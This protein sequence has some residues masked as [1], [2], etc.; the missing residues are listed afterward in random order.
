MF[1]NNLLMGAAAA[2]SGG[3]S[4]VSVG[5]S[6]LFTSNSQELE[7][8]PSG[9]GNVDKWT[10]STWVYFGDTTNSTSIPI[11]GAINTS[12]N[13]NAILISS[14]G[15]IYFQIYLS[16]AHAGRLITTQLLRDIGWYH[17]VVVYDSGNAIASNR[18][19]V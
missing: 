3:A 18:E 19:M 12:A 9:A 8:T 1:N 14:T 5:N 10:F 2:A 17:I 6:S 13:Q 11:F 4:V 7:R 16:S 15:Q